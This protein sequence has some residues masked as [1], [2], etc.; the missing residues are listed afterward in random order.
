MDLQEVG[1]GGIAWIDLAQDR[2]S[3]CGTERSG[4]IKAGNFL[5]G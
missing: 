2:D 5:T 4:S 1:C 3:E